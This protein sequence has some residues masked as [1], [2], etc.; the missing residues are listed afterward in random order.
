[1]ARVL[2]ADDHPLFREAIQGTAARALEA[3]GLPCTIVEAADYD[4]VIEIAG[5]GRDLDIILL[6]IFMPGSAGLAGLGRLRSLV[7]GT[8]IVI[9]SSLCDRDS[10]CQAMAC[11]VAGYIPKTAAKEVIALALQIVLAGGVYFPPEILG[12]VVSPA[13]P[14]GRR[15]GAGSGAER[16]TARQLAVLGLLANGN[17]NKEIARRLGI[18]DGTVKV[19]MTAILAK[20]KVT[21]RA[22]AIASFHRAP[23]ETP[24]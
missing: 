16:L 21:T 17:S 18:S 19:H 11:G 14:G 5:D 23:S 7:P 20:L 4:R 24:A 8:P 2:I 3:L 10:V 1:M 13:A 9:V 6:D 12:Q 22:Q 15:G